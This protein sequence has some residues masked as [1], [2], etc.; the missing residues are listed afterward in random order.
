[1][2]EEGKN[3]KLKEEMQKKKE[4]QEKKM[5]KSFYPTFKNPMGFV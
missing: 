3:Q 5:L 1:M 2:I 4:E